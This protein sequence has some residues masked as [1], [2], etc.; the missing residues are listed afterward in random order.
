MAAEIINEDEIEVEQDQYVVFTV[1]GQ[2]FGFRAMQVREISTVLGTT[3]VPNA[4]P[5]IEGIL[6]LRGE[7]TSVINFRKKF[8][9]DPKE[10][11]EDTRIII[12]EHGDFPIGIVVDS[13]EEVIKIPD[14]IV[15]KIP[16]STTTPVS[17]AY[18]TGVGMLENRLIILLDVEKVLTKTELMELGEISQMMNAEQTECGL[19]NEE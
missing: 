8:G 18:M 1:K 14:E 13:V 4:P 15:Q 16:E 10:H 7:L 2:E 11:D 12:V 6:N 17:K 9:F 5:Y 3:E 19:T